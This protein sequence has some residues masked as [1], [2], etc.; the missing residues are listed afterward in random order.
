LR[1]ALKKGRS[2]RNIPRQGSLILF[3]RKKL[4][5]EEA[6]EGKQKGKGGRAEGGS[7]TLPKHHGFS[8]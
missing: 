2:P 5:A 8:L 6:A 7:R 4:I 1:I 3:K